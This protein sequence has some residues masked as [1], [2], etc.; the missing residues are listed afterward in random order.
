MMKRTLQ[1]SFD[2]EKRFAIV[3][4]GWETNRPCLEPDASS[5]EHGGLVYH[6]A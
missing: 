1:P 5:S 6:L 3:N 4:A 2:V